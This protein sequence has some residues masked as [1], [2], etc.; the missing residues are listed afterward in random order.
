VLVI[1]TKIL[2]DLERPFRT[3]FQN[4]WRQVSYW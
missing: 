4:T 3:L 2:D 1:G